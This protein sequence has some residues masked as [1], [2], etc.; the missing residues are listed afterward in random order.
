MAPRP[1]LSWTAEDIAKLKE[2][3]GSQ[4]VEKIAADLGRTPGAVAVEASKLHISLRMGRRAGLRHK[5]V[6]AGSPEP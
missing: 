4:K 1:R 2:M 3:A 6:P 5:D